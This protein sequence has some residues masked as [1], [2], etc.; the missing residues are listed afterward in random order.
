[1]IGR[2][3]RIVAG[4]PPRAASG[5]VALETRG[6]ATKAGHRDVSLRLHKGEI[7]GLYGL[8]GAGR[9]ELAR[10]IVGKDAITGGELRIGATPVRIGSVREALKRYRM[11]YVSEDRKYEGVILGHAVRPNVAMTIWNRLAR[12]GL[13]TAQEERRAVQ[14]LVGELQVRTPSL[15]QLVG[16]L[17]GGNQ[18]KVSLAKW[19]AAD[20]EIL[21]VDEPTVGID[22]QTKSYIHELIGR[23][24]DKGTSILLISSDMPEMIAL[25]DRILVMRDYALVGAFENDRQYETM[26]RQI[27]SAIHG[28]EP[29][30]E[31]AQ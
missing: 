30:S 28:A 15:E 9:T 6:L 24:A 11:G 18:Q 19:L 23:L 5:P 4:R 31:A 7:L 17:S 20:V 22:I 3:E 25:A 13:I 16:N 21:I 8:V 26:S 14:P 2:S 27:M 29:T 12:S 1:M 10:A